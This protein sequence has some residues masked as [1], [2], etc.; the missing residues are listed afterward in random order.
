MAAG[1]VVIV[2]GAVTAVVQLLRIL[3]HRKPARPVAGPA[4]RCTTMQCTNTHALFRG[5]G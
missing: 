3:P 4:G 2:A 5:F 1:A